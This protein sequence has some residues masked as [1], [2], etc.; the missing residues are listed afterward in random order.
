MKTRSR[1]RTIGLVSL[2]CAK[3]LIDSELLQKQLDASNLKISFD[4]SSIKDLDTI[5]INTCGF[6]G[7]AKQESVE[8]ILQ[9]VHAKSE[10]KLKHVFVMGCLSER[11]RDQLKKDI[12]EVDAFYGVN[13]LKTIVKD[14]G[15]HYN[16]RLLGERMI[17][18]PSHYAYLKIAE[19]CDRKCSFCAI[20]G[21][22]GGHISRSSAD[23]LK[24]AKGLVANGVK[25]I[26]VISQDTTFYG[27]D[28]YK[29]RQIADLLEQLAGVDENVWIRLHYAYPHGFPMDIFPVIRDHANIC[30]YIDIPLQHI[31]N[32]IL[33]SM[34]R[35]LS[36]AKT[37]KLI[38]TIRKEIPGVILRSSFIAGYPGETDT[39]FSELLDFVRDAGFDRLGVFAYSHEEGT[40]AYKLRDDISQKIKHERVSEIMALQEQISLKKNIAMVGKQIKIL[41]DRKEGDY[42]IARSEGDS[43]EIDNEVLIPLT[44]NKLK[45]G[46]FSEVKVI[47]AESFD[48][49]AEPLGMLGI[50]RK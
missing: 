17:S 50:S 16:K 33:K 37:R 48:L 34:K 47:S 27:F 12:P 15:G 21:I 19:G 4:P 41:I 1:S 18:T 46:T 10:G 35:G 30:K 5:V 23:I 6:I 20:P 22:R 3:N 45:P 13:E 25:E 11:Y 43:P 40:S 42:Y 49:Y 38:E 39:E 7:D 32:R 8:T 24:E 2:G 31:N 44:G 14:L 9:Y 36:S 28:L 26:I 29:R